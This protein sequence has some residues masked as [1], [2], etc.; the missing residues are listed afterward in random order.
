MMAETTQGYM[1]AAKSSEWE[2]PWKFFR[3]LDREFHFTLDPCA[4]PENAKCERYFTQEQD[5]LAQS[6][7]GEVVFMNPPYGRE[8]AAWIM[9][10][11]AAKA[12]TQPGRARRGGSVSS[13]G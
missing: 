9:K 1:P 4:T 2:T 13:G 5:G 3:E 10:A 6:W 8:I 11:A 12:T 7:A